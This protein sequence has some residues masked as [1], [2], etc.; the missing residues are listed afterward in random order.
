MLRPL[1]FVLNPFFTTI[2]F[3]FVFGGLAKLPTDGM[4]QTLFYYSGTMLW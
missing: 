4:P 3:S 2:V 1:W